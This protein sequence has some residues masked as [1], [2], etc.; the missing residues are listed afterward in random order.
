MRTEARHKS[1]LGVRLIQSILSHLSFK[2]HFNIQYVRKVAVHL[3]KV[4]EVMSTSVY[5]SMSPFNFIRKHL[6]QICVRKVAVH[7]QKVME[8]MSTSVYTGMSPFYFIRKHFLQICVRKVAVHLQN[9]LQV[10]STSVCTD[11][12]P[13]RTVA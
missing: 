4:M 8:V 2:L 13:Y 10:M 12:N 5:T 11:L 7:L 6:L 1:L 9:M 3:Q